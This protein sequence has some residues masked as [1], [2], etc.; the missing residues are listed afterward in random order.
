MGS[1]YIKG[2]LDEGIDTDTAIR[3]HLQN[4]H[5]PPYE[6]GFIELMLP[7]IKKAI[8]WG[9]DMQNDHECELSTD[10]K[11]LKLPKGIEFKGSKKATALDI[12]TSFHLESFIVD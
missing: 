11:W 5:Y 4:N 3:I 6:N 2:F 1:M 8:A 7:V 12:I 10:N 9:Q